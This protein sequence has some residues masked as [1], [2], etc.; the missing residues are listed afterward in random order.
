[1][2][3][4][5]IKNFGLKLK[6]RAECNKYDFGHILVIAGSKNMVGA[7]VLCANAVMRC[8]AGL[9]TYACGENFLAQAAS[10][11]KPESMFFSYRN[12]ED[13]INFVKTRKVSAAVIGP[14]LQISRGLKG[15]I[16]KIISSIDIAVVL[17]ASALSAYSSG[18]VSELKS[19]KAKLILTPHLGEFAKLQSIDKD[20]VKTIKNRIDCVKNFSK[21]N[22][23][24]CLLKG[25]NT[26][27]SDGNKVYVNG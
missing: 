13:V 22:S 12:S 8:G 27:V 19:A 17:D 6:R 5:E 21:R 14:G 11:S 24:I 2:N 15:F 7:G 10:M 1:M 23:L 4:S 18:K 3:A 9:V 25:R 20:A 16:N 26:I